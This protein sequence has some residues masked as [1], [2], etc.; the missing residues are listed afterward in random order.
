MDASE[1]FNTQKT[2]PAAIVENAEKWPSSQATW[3]GF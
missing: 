3:S 1:A 2:I